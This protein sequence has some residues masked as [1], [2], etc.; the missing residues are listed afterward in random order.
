MGFDSRQDLFFFLQNRPNRPWAHPVVYSGRPRRSLPG[1][2]T[3]GGVKLT[4]HI[5]LMVRLRMGGPIPSLPTHVYIA[6]NMGVILDFI[7][8][9]G[10]SCFECFC[11]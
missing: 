9:F 8:K 7:V 1:D 11:L 4:I 3:V 2:K 5:H 6:V 10:S